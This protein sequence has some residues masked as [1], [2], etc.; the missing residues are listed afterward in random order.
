M[1]TAGPV[2]IKFADGQTEDLA[3][4]T[5]ECSTLELI[6]KARLFA[7]SWVGSQ[8]KQRTLY[9]SYKQC[10]LRTRSI[11]LRELSALRPALLV[12]FM[13]CD[14]TCSWNKAVTFLEV[15]LAPGQPAPVSMSLLY[16]L[17]EERK[18]SLAMPAQW[19]MRVPAAG[20][21]SLLS[22]GALVTLSSSSV[23]VLCLLHCGVATPHLT[24]VSSDR[25]GRAGSLRPLPGQQ[26]GAAPPASCPRLSPEA[27]QVR[28]AKS[29]PATRHVRLVAAGRELWDED[30]VAPAACGVLHCVAS[31]A[32]PPHGRRRRPRHDEQQG[33]DWVRAQVRFPPEPR[34]GASRGR[35]LPAGRGGLACCH[36]VPSQP[37]KRAQPFRELCTAPARLRQRAR[38]RGAPST[39]TAAAA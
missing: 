27:P 8:P 33:V 7:A 1:G 6:E 4:D 15:W 32:A 28:A 11:G 26:R 12:R 24:G 17:V 30:R 34:L 36:A 3:L 18:L 14:G 19:H 29:W 16:R 21:A 23:S 13:R 35:R 37:G 39:R 31:D 9:S 10:G 20:L 38:G 22:A 25:E 2:V 5:A